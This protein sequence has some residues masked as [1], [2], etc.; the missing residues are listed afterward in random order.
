LAAAFFAPLVL[1]FM[2]VVVF[3][4]VV[5]AR[6]SLESINSI[7]PGPIDTD[8]NPADGPMAATMHGFMAIKRH[9]H[10]NEIAD[11]AAFLASPSAAMITGSTQTIDGGFGV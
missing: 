11:Y 8:M 6:P 2:V 9:I 5:V 7:Q 3:F 10:T 1:F 4:M